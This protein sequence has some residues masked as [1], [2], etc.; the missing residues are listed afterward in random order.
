MSDPYAGPAIPGLAYVRRLGSGGFGDVYLYENVALKRREAVKVIRDAD[1]SPAVVQRFM[2]EA[3]AMAGLEHPHIVRVYGTGT[4][5]D[6]RPYLTMQFYSESTMEDRA[7][8]GRLAI[9]EVL[10]TGIEIGGALETAHRAGMLHRD[11]K[12]ANILVTSWGAAGLTD[13]G[14]AA[15]MASDTSDDD[16]GVSVPWAPPEMI[17]SA[18]RG[19]RQS[20]VYSL[21]ATLW[22]LI[23]GRS[24]FEVPGGDN[25]RL[26]MMSRVRDYPPPVTGR[27]DCP[28]SLESLLRQSMAK[29][30]G[31]RPSTVAEFCRSLQMVEDELRLPRTNLVILDQHLETRPVSAPPAAGS[32]TAEAG[33][34]M[35]PREGTSSRMAP[36]GRSE[37]ALA[38]TQRRATPPTARV[39]AAGQGSDATQLRPRVTELA[40][41]RGP[42][43][44][45]AGSH[46]VILVGA[47]VLLVIAAVVIGV[48][49]L[50]GRGGPSTPTPLSTVSESAG[51]IDE[52]APPPG[53]VKVEAVR[54]ADAVTFSWSYDNQ[55]TTDTYRLQFAGGNT[56]TSDE[57]RTTVP[58]AKGAKVCLSVIVV[59]SDGS[60][61]TSEFPKAVCG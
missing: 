38:E 46:R 61:P 58:A 42:D 49:L 16:V 25:S 50:G 24:P 57:P 27:A 34:V 8:G 48:M 55:L 2:A 5:V 1:L 4:T 31:A 44:E 33:T 14:V 47:G 56:T 36:D 13:F 6:G 37:D 26:A 54:S 11:V 12:P 20:D 9:S 15:Q 35:R 52:E 59:R 7:S 60:N 23:T 28:A 41:E 45:A 39:G 3:N 18:T 17:Y 10:R 32:S 19:S 43:P 51:P 40:V 22:H 53:R 29:Q 21:A 30:P